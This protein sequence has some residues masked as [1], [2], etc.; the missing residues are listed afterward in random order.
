LPITSRNHGSEILH[1][2]KWHSL[3]IGIQSWQVHTTVGQE[4]ARE[5]EAEVRRSDFLFVFLTAASSVSEMVKGEVEIARDQAGKSGK[6]PVFYRF[7]SHIRD[8]SLTL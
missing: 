6:E 7:D 2:K 8:P 1:K 4:W 5:I 3:Q